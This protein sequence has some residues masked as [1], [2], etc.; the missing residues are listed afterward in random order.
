M[1]KIQYEKILSADSLNR[2]RTHLEKDGLIIYPTD[3]LYGIGCNFY[4]IKAQ[5]KIDIIKARHDMPYSVAI[6]G[7]DM[8]KEIVDDI[9]ELFNKFYKEM[10]PGKFTFLMGP[11]RSVDKKLIKNSIRIGIRI[12]DIPNIIKMIRYLGFPVISTSV[13][14]SGQISMNSPDEIEMFLKKEISI[15]LSDLLFVDK[16]VLP[17]SKGS[18][19]VDFSGKDIDLIRKGDDFSKFKKFLKRINSGRI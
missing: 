4:S 7:L 13:N 9:P 19:I 12:P 10:L 2:I 1:L 11:A 14:R 17:V 15:P 5:N 18:T 6:S 8:L 3:T 16:G